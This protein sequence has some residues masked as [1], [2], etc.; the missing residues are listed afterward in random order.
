[1]GDGESLCLNHRLE[2][3][4]S[5]LSYPCRLMRLLRSIIL[6]LL[7]TVDRLRNQLPVSHAIAAQFVS[8]DLSG[9]AA[10]VTQ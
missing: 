6:I 1:M 3:S 2:L 9:F 7:G 8:H 10:M 5:S 4:H